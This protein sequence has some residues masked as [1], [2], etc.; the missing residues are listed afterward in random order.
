MLFTHL[1]VIKKAVITWLE[2]SYVRK[3]NYIFKI[4]LAKLIILKT[5]NKLDY[6]YWLIGLGDDIYANN[7]KVFYEY[8]KDHH[9][10][11]IMYWVCRKDNL[12]YFE[13]FINKDNLIVRG[14]IKNYLLAFEA[15]AAIYGFSD[16]DIA[17]GL[18]RIFKKHKAIVVNISHGFDGLKG[19]PKNYY[20]ALPAD[21]ICAASTYEKNAKIQFCGADKEKVYLTGFARYDIWPI[22]EA[23]ML[24]RSRKIFIMPTWRDW[25]EEESI[26]WEDSLLF[27]KYVKFLKNLDDLAKINNLEIICHFHPRMQTFFS[28]P[29]IQSLSRVKIDNDKS[30]IQELLFQA[31]IIITDYSSILWDAIYMG[32]LV[33]LYWFDYNE[34][35]S[36]RGLMVEEDFYPYISRNEEIIIEWIK[37]SIEN[38]FNTQNIHEKYFDW[39]D[40]SNCD[41]IYNL[42]Q[43]K[44]AEKNLG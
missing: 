7:G 39:Q 31:D 36:K 12:K 8:M 16:R 35:K 3:V 10:D 13:N 23:D 37:K 20:S 14:S 41:R 4:L 44:V 5:R 1:N 38:K 24:K 43:K 25:Y 34:Y 6:N 9:K 30:S 21:I 15:E 32:K 33:F 29:Q 28:N 18:F 42:I 17:P 27:K 11:I 19:M 2:K 22:N 40:K 26:V